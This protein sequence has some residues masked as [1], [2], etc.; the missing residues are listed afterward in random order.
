VG[1]AVAHARHAVGVTV[2]ASRYVFSMVWPRVVFIA[3][4]GW[5][6]FSVL[7]SM[8]A[9]RWL[10]NGT[11][12][13]VVWLYV[14]RAPEIFQQMMGPAVVLG[15]LAG[16]GQLNR[17]AELAALSSGGRS[18]RTTVLPAVLVVSGGAALLH[19]TLGE[20]VVPVAGR[21]ALR[22]STDVFKIFGGRYWDFHWRSGWFRAG[23]VYARAQPAD[24]DS[25][26]RV[27]GVVLEEGVGV[28]SRFVAQRMEAAPTPGHFVLQDAVITSFG[29][30]PRVEVAARKEMDMPAAAAAL[31][32]PMG[33]PEHF[34]AADL[35]RTIERREAG[36]RDAAAYRLALLRRMTDP[37]MVLLLGLLAVPLAARQRREAPVERLLFAGGLAVA[38]AQALSMLGDMLAARAVLPGW[39]A[40]AVAPALVL[41]GAVLTWR[42]AEHARN[43]R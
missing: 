7:D 16:V 1:L 32:A 30:P 21:E 10:A 26:E 31:T 9:A 12:V 6:L 28:T 3:V 20:Y 19:A 39:L 2:V 4:A 27:M 22:L 36:G 35:A 17:R 11:M 29:P 8:E 23:P 5:L 38:T 42:R 43:A 34:T 14:C 37:I 40:A 25:Y 18:L 33:Y 41:L 13:Q 24:A 15:V